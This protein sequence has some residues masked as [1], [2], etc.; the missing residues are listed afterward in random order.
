MTISGGSRLTGDLVISGAKN[1]ALPILA[2]SLLHTEEVCI[3]NVPD[4]W[5]IS[6][7][8]ALLIQLGAKVY[9]KGQSTLENASS[10]RH[11]IV[12]SS[13][14]N[15]M[16]APYDLVCK[17][18]A[19]VLVLGPL[20]GRFG[21][22]CVSLPGGCAIGTRP[23]DMHIEA[24]KA[25]GAHI[26]ISN[27]YVVATTNGRLS[28]AEI[29]FDKVSVGATENVMMAA[30]LADGITTIYNAACEPEIVDLA[31]FLNSGGARIDGAGT[32][33]I[34]I[35]GVD[36]LHATLHRVI[37]DRIEAGTY[38]IAAMITKGSL[39]LHDIS[40]VLLSSCLS[41]L[42][43]IGAE[44][45]EGDN[46]IKVSSQNTFKPLDI[47]TAPYPDFATDLQ[48]QIMALLSIAEGQSLVTESIF[49]NRFMHALELNRMGA[50]ISVKEHT[51]IV[52]GVKGLQG[53]EVMATDLRASVALILAAL[54]AQGESTIR[55]VYHLYRGYEHIEGKL[56]SCGANIKTTVG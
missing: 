1:S 32:S 25:L 8:K 53:A 44:I 45:S 56:R 55:R 4:L 41:Y 13:N 35:N 24:I 54:S 2:A 36:R 5:D 21:K 49:E 31:N 19:S 39:T 43:Q 28:G 42:R 15:N 33:V 22:A 12:D 26:E 17:M 46:Y 18:R 23:V 14:V 30:V 29:R 47:K 6:A 37:P 9:E 27:G 10:N 20:V 48:A 7:M 38:A 52:N 51:A 50:N 11:L 34:T 40:P 3:Q 16:T